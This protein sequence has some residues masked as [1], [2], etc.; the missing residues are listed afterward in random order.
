MRVS[1]D[2][3]FDAVE[4]GRIQG[5]ARLQR[6]E[7]DDAGVAGPVLADADGVPHLLEALHLAVYF[8]GADPHAAGVEHRVAAAV[9]QVAA[10]G[11]DLGEVA[12]GPNP[13]K[14]VEVG[15]ME[16]A[17]IRISPKPQRT[18]RE[19]PGADQLALVALSGRQGLAVVAENLHR[20]SQALALQLARVD[21]AVG[22]AEDEA[23]YQVGAA[24][25]GN[26]VQVSLDG[27]VDV[28]KALR[29]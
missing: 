11:G 10:V 5:N 17:A 2:L 1:A 21:G 14:L 26:E 7:Q 4:E 27:A 3:I 29:R 9:D 15:V 22:V 16:A 25:H 19:G 8:R 6:H 23:G 13:G 28:L 24:G 18:G 12:V 20:H